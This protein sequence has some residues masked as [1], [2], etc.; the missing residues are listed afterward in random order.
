MSELLREAIDS[1]L[2]GVHIEDGSKAAY[3][4][5]A[6][7][8]DAAISEKI[9]SHEIDHYTESDPAPANNLKE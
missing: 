4:R 2:S 5:V 8:L 6:A 9:K 1:V 7:A 3:E